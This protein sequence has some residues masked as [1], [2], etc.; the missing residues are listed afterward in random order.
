[1]LLR[2]SQWDAEPLA[3]P[4]PY[5]TGWQFVTIDPEDS[6][7]EGDINEQLNLCGETADPWNILD[8]MAVWGALALAGVFTPHAPDDRVYGCDWKPEDIINGGTNESPSAEYES[9]RTAISIIWERV[10]PGTLIES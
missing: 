8:S 6:L 1:M 4:E 2:E 10:S 5:E 9:F 3:A 7:V